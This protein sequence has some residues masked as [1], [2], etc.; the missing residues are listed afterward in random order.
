MRSIAAT[1]TSC[2]CGD[3]DANED[4]RPALF[5]ER[6]ANVDLSGMQGRPHPSVKAFLRMRNV[7]DAFLHG[8]HPL[9][10]DTFLALEGADCKGAI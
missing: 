5:T 7:S 4:V 10:P 6:C 9:G 8:N 1:W 2:A 3:I